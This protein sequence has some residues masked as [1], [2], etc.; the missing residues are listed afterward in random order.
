[1]K[2]YKV[3]SMDYVDEFRCVGNECE[4]TCCKDWVIT[5]DKKTYLKYKNLPSVEFKTKLMDCVKRNR[6][7][8]NDYDYA[9]IKLINNLC[10]M[11]TEEGLCGIYTNIGEESMCH[12]CK[13]YPR[14]YNIVD[15]RIEYS[16]TLS[17]I[18]VAKGLLTRKSPIEFNFDMK[19]L[20][21]VT[22]NK[23]IKTLNGKRLREKYFNEIRSF[24]IGLIQ[25]R[26]FSIEERLSILGLF[27]N[28]INNISEERLVL[29]TIE[30][31]ARNIENGEYGDLLKDIDENK[32]MDAQLE[33]L[34]NIYNVILD[35]NINNQKYL[36]SINFIVNNFRLNSKDLD[37][38]KESYKASLDEYYNPFMKKYEY[39]YENY[40]VSYMFKNLFPISNM[41]LLDTYVDLVV[42][43]AI[44]K[45]NLIG[46]CGY[47]K[48]NMDIDKVID[49]VQSFVLVVE[50]DNFMINKLHKYLSENNLSTVAHMVILMGK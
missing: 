48:E 9:K 4:D 20:S 10:P 36:Q 24:S 8:K 23:K 25:N 1:M 27:I 32:N 46:I 21:N 31:Y 33:F 14:Y 38:M 12:T 41:S 45:M 5:V 26:N 6:Q 43:F 29:D 50:H 37:L 19:E 35:K 13:V 40:L 49:L 28:S 18:E 11:L 17:C 30:R 7:S 47:Y 22:P 34:I 3:L 39:I 2:K 16:L 44:I 42:H 15:D